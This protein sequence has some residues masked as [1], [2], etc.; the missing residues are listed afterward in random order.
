MIKFPPYDE[1]IK[2][3]NEIL[4]TYDPK[5]KI[6]L[7]QLFYQLVIRKIIENELKNYKLLSAKL[8]KAREDGDVD[9]GRF[10]DEERPVIGGDADSED[11]TG[12]YEDHE[13]SFRTCWERYSRPRWWGQ[14]YYVE[15]FVEKRALV[16]QIAEVAE[17]YGVTTCATRGYSS[18]TFIVNAIDRIMRCCERWEGEPGSIRKPVILQFGD[19]DP[20]GVDMTRDQ[21]ERLQ[22][23][24]LI[25]RLCELGCD[26][27]YCVERIALTAEQ[28][29]QYHLPPDPAKIKD[30]RTKKFIEEYGNAAVELDALDAN[31]LKK[32][33]KE[34]I[35]SR[36]DARIWNGDIDREEKERQQIRKLV[37][38]HFGG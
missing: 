33:V 25:E 6:T 5:E 30:K 20:S 31:V 3:V 32:L 21:E 27:D 2:A 7:R 26:I 8:V 36:I 17:P 24:G 4:A 37:E 19:R 9:D 1:L 13:D 38:K 15:I 23:Y 12:Y 18:Y 11:P 14:D 35:E 28:I 16:K 34:A 10:E 22:R 29:E